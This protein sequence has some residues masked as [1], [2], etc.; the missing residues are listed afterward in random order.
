MATVT[1]ITGQTALVT[2]AAKRL[3]AA[4]AL[5]LAN[6]GV[7]VVVHY[8]SSAGEAESVAAHAR[9]RGVNA[10]TL[11]ADLGDPGAAEHL[12]D[13]A[14]GLAG[15]I[16]ILV[17]NASTFPEGSLRDCSVAD[18]E[19]NIRLNALSPFLMGRRFAAQNRDGCIINLLDAMIAD[20]DRKH[21]PYHLSKRL[22]HSL[23]RMM[24][25]EFAPKIRVN[26]VAPGLVLPPEGKDVSYL[27]ALASSNPLHTC[28]DAA[29][30]TEAILFLLRSRF[31][32]GQTI[33]VDGGRHLRGRMYD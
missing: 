25:V 31:V 14:Q 28:G 15:S 8:R 22:L 11:C 33:F 24:A 5:A 3:G 21:V 18:I 4:T 32:T 16:D 9:A 29:C 30:V 2:G 23:T 12:V 13:A 1:T 10:W 26:A 20:Y 17:N 19:D 7:H 27:A 6:A